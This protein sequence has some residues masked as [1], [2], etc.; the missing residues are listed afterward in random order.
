MMNTIDNED[1]EICENCKGKGNIQ[2]KIDT[3]IFYLRCK[4]CFGAGRL[5]W[6]EKIF[7]KDEEYD[8][9]F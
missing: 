6:V 2:E 9:I 4:K 3:T 8:G 1:F 7:G 5:N